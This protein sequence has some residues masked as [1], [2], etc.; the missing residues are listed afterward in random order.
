V[1]RRACRQRARDIARDGLTPVASLPVV[2]MCNKVR[3]K[4]GIYSINLIGASEQR[5][6]DFE[7]KRLR[8][9]EVDD[10]NV[11]GRLLD[12]EVGPAW[13]P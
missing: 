10:Q 2:S 12:W 3:V 6:R 9:F 1:R 11:F 13:R 5:R 8:G 4:P 7:A